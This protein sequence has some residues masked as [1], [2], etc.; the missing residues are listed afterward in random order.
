MK[1]SLALLLLV[2]S[3]VP[4]AIGEVLVTRRV[5]VNSIYH[6]GVQRP[7]RTDMMEIW[8]APRRLAC[9]VGPVKI[10][11]DADRDLLILVN[12]SSKTYA[13]AV[14]SAA[15]T[16][17]MTTDDR[18]AMP[19]HDTTAKV[20]ATAETR[21]ILGRSCRGFD[22]AFRSNLDHK[23][24]AWVSADA[25]FDM[26]AYKTLMRKLYTFLGRFDQASTEALLGLPGYVLSQENVADLKG[27]ILRVNRDVVA[28]VEKT[29]PPDLFSVPEGYARRPGL[30]HADV[31]MIASI[32][33]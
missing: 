25:P 12:A 29:A 6:E 16:A 8:I 4:A 2:M 13:Q 17:S 27:E 24:R 33:E 28:M 23:A 32:L 9:L 30:T 3:T 14:L 5:H 11:V 7:E 19:S 26:E 21:D 15:V 20:R 18:E 10:I 22:I 1:R 31:D